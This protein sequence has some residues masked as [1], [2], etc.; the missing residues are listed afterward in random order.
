LKKFIES[1]GK[2]EKFNISYIGVRN[3]NRT[4]EEKKINA[5]NE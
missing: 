1:L 2:M 3:G 4:T 5:E